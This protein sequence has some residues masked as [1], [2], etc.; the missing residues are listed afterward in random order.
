MSVV[1]EHLIYGLVDPRTEEL[2][3]IGQ[4]MKTLKKRLSQHL[5]EIKTKKNSLKLGWLRELSKLG[6]QPDIVVLDEYDAVEPTKEQTKNWLDTNEVLAIDFYREA[7]CRLTNMTDGGEGTRLFGP[8]NGTWGKPVSDE[9]KK[10]ISESLV[11][12]PSGRLGTGRDPVEKKCKKCGEKFKTKRE[13]QLYC[14]RSCYTSSDEFRVNQRK[15]IES[16]IHNKGKKIRCL[17]DGMMYPSE[18]ALVRSLGLSRTTVI[19]ALKKGRE[20]AGR[21]FEYVDDDSHDTLT[22][23]LRA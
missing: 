21:K 1:T 6:C 23:G 16:L 19:C 2:R 13:E 18:R 11:G 7:G 8:A 9:R 3:Y 12:R 15:S 5:A 17:N 22:R 14:D 4:T 20:I 10:K